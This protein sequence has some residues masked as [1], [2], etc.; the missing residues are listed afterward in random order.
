MVIVDPIGLATLLN[1]RMS[2]ASTCSAVHSAACLHQHALVPFS[3]G[4]QTDD[5]DTGAPII[6]QIQ[7]QHQVTIL[8]HLSG[9]RP[10]EP[11]S[12]PQQITLA[13]A[14]ASD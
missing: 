1:E 11:P 6:L 7:Q 9:G 14:T 8:A 4:P 2:V 5:S 3:D 12:Q 13:M 10:P